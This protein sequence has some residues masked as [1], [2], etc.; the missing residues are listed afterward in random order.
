MTFHSWTVELENAWNE[1]ITIPSL[2]V[3]LLSS[4]EAAIN[5]FI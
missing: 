5:N 1:I 2:E 4:Q 3:M